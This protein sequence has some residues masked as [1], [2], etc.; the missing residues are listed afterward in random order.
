MVEKHIEATVSGRVQGVW[1][2]AFVQT[3]AIGLG[4]NGYVQN[5]PDGRVHLVAVGP[6]DRVNALLEALN[7]GPPGARVEG[8][9]A[10]V[11]EGG[12]TFF[13]FTIRN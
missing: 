10:R 8:V 3:T 13:D 7:E 2:R 5:L 12:E 1:F 9:E 11:Y 6:A 4:V